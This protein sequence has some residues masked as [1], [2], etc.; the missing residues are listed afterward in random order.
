M[1]TAY[2]ALGWNVADFANAF[3]YYQ[4]LVSLPMHTRLSDE[5]VEYICETLQKVVKDLNLC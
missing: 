1:M 4:N 5:D 3:D 2:K